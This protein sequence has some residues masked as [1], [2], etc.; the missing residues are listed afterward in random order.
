[1]L[2]DF[3]FFFS[4]LVVLFIVINSYHQ[5]KGD[6]VYIK[7]G[8]RSFL[9]RN[10]EGKADNISKEKAAEKLNMVMDNL[11]KIKDHMV[12]N[13][14]DHPATKRMYRNFSADSIS[15]S[16]PESEYTSYSLNKGEKI[17]MCIRNKKNNQF[18]DSNTIMFVAIHELAHVMT[19]SIGH[20][21]EF[22]DNMTILLCEAKK[23]GAYKLKDYS[24]AVPYC[25]T[26]ITSTPLKCDVNKKNDCDAKCKQLLEDFKK[27]K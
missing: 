1:M 25:G 2:K 24:A 6:M 22:W 27:E 3:I 12:K 11:V 21:K 23:I 4:G 16:L 14:P 20:K 15:E 17:A 5:I 18:I 8:G 10:V 13:Y 26:T 7:N 9:V 19:E